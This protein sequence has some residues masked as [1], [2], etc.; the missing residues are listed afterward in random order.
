ML[1]DQCL[2]VNQHDNIV[3]QASKKDTHVFSPAQ[4]Q[5][6]LHRAFSVFL[7]NEEGKLLLQQRAASKITFPC[8][9]TNTCCSHQ[10][11]GFDPSEVDLPDAVS[12][13]SVMGSKRAAVRKLG[14]ELGIPAHQ[15][16]LKGFRY[17]TR[18]HYCAADP[19]S[20]GQEPQWGE[21]EMDYILFSRAS[22]DVR[23]NAEEV[24]DIKWVTLPELKRLMAPS[25]GL[26]WS[27]WF[28]I[29]VENHL[30]GWWQDLQK[31]LAVADEQSI[32]GL[33]SILDGLKFNSDGLV[34]AIAQNVDT[35]AVLMQA[36][37]NRAAVAETLQTRL[38][39]F[40]SRSRKER[41]CKGET[42]GHFIKVTGVYVDCDGDSLIYL[43]EP[44]GP[45]CHTGAE[46][47]WFSQ[48]GLTDNSSDGAASL[49]AV[50]TTQHAQ[51]TLLA[52]ESTIRQRRE[53]MSQNAGGKPSWTAR[54][55]QNPELLCSKVREEAGELCQTLEQDEGKERAASEMA[56][57]LYHSMVLLNLQGV[58]MEEVLKAIRSR[59]GTSG[60]EEKASRSKK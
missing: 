26:K 18:L 10:L 54:L 11:S 42:S 36:F 29:L 3:G 52:L 19:H 59:F 48:V 31:T 1:K 49:E 40:Y 5:G 28:R 17:L 9:W 50:Q 56:D 22:V 6:L 32:S 20:K 51:P 53:Q 38:A 13:G 34:V 43:G 21:H 24:S 47:C 8:V 45:A 12:N 14:H 55:L 46:T 4:P 2:L 33:S 37:A 25:S 58:K 35:G 57:L 60:V 15:I 16:P 23:P 41:W 30:D 39:T 27:P 44:I 7:F